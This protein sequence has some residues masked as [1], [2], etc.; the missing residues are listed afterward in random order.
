MG[1]EES[2]P[3]ATIAVDNIYK[4]AYLRIVGWAPT[5][6]KGFHDTIIDSSGQKI[7]HCYPTQQEKQTTEVI[8]VLYYKIEH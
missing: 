8:V 5:S 2:V 3:A 6:H 1:G 4:C 7:A